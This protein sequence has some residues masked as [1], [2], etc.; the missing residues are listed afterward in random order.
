MASYHPGVRCWRYRARGASGRPLLQPAGPPGGDQPEPGSTPNAWPLHSAPTTSE[1]PER[2]DEDGAPVRVPVAQSQPD[3]SP[4]ITDPDAF[5]SDTEPMKF[6]A[7]ETAS[8]QPEATRRRTRQLAIK[9]D[10][11]SAFNGEPLVSEAELAM[12]LGGDDEAR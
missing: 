5:T 2:V 7:Y 4:P 10:P 8:A 3:D 9:I 1:S 6:T 11:R 12:L